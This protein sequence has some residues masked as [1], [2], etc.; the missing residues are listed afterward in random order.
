MRHSFRHILPALSLAAAS[1]FLPVAGV[2]S[3]AGADPVGG[4]MSNTQMI[5]AASSLTLDGVPLT[6]QANPNVFADSSGNYFGLTLC[7]DTSNHAYYFSV[8][9]TVA[10]G[11]SF[12]D[13]D[14]S[15][16]GHSFALTFTANP[17]TVP[18][19][20][21]LS[22]LA[23]AGPQGLVID[24][25][26]NTVTVRAA[27]LGFSDI[28]QCPNTPEVCASTISQASHDHLVNW[29]G[30]VRYRTND[31]N[32]MTNGGAGFSDL[33]G[34]TLS[35]GAYYFTMA[36]SCPTNPNGDKSFTGLQ[37]NEGGP[38]FMAD[39]A[40]P[41]TTALQAFIPAEALAE[42]FGLTPSAFAL[43]A[44]L[45][46]TEYGTTTALVS[47]TN[48]TD[49]TAAGLIYNL[50]SSDAGVTISVP[51]VTFSKPTYRFGA[52]GKVLSTRTISSLAASL[53]VAKPSGGS[54]RVQ[55]ASASTSVCVATTVK[56][57]AFNRGS[58][59]FT[60]VARAKGGAIT[61][62][63]SGTFTQR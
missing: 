56:V 58:C 16:A 59:R 23:P 29:S 28:W 10:D 49:A 9:A 47:Q 60:V 63:A 7:N 30:S 2:A 52:R 43:S 35:S 5:S 36:A 53:H 27:T 24:P 22:A 19:V 39:G 55:V 62:R 42:C 34:L 13:L 48:A 21:Q 3:P 44:Q 33:P 51:T 45:S 1:V 6:P 57:F 17:G 46:R 41:N 50:S 26:A 40:T 11:S 31:P 54:L 18:L 4:C 12:S 38:H 8:M 14:S 15:L 61:R 32:P 37:I 20:A 25:V